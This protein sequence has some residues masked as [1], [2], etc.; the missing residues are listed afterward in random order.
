MSKLAKAQ[1]LAAKGDFPTA[2]RR[3]ADLHGRDDRAPLALS[4]VRAASTGPEAAVDVLREVV[5]QTPDSAPAHVELGIAQWD[6]GN[7]AEAHAA[8]ARVVALQPE[9]DVALSYLAL[10]K[11]AT[12]EAAAAREIYRQHGFNDNRMFRVRLTEWMERQWLEHDRFFMQRELEPIQPAPRPSLRRA[13]K[14]FYAKK[15]PQML[16]EL[17]PM[18][19][20]E[21]GDE[22]LHYAC[23]LGAEMLQ[24]YNA[25]LRYFAMEVK[26]PEPGFLSKLSEKLRRF[27]RRITG[28]PQLEETEPAS[29]DA[30]LALRGRCR[31]RTRDFTGAAED[32]GQ[33]LV[34][35]PEDYA[36]KYYLGVLCLAHGE[37]KRAR[38]FFRRAHTDYMVDTLE[39]QWWQIEGA[40]FREAD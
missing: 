15:Y 14:Y 30:V 4:R 24:D 16:A 27:W 7:V 35:G 21:P 33:V 8:F 17:Q 10:S 37:D 34:L 9:N 11:L 5:T 32:L 38:E 26:E 36:L 29:Q 39:F 18:L 2:E 25:A 31:L 6:A 40:L 13:Q 28:K 3:L 22:S 12:G 20:Q 1:R 23:A 19:E